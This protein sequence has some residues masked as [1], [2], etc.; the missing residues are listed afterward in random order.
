MLITERAKVLME[1]VL[2]HTM[3]KASERGLGWME[4]A[5]KIHLARGK[6]LVM[7]EKAVGRAARRGREAFR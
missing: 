6:A 2:A 3:E 7:T 1:K 5:V 4:K